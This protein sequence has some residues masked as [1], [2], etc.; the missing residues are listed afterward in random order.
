MIPGLDS[1]NHRRGEPVTWEYRNDTTCLFVRTE[2]TPN[3][4]IFNNYGAKSNEELLAS[5]GFV[6]PSGPDDVLVLALRGGDSPK[7]YYWQQSQADP[8]EELLK[9]LQEQTPLTSDGDPRIAGLLQQA[10]VIE[11][12]EQFIR[13]R[14]SLFVR[15]QME[16]D[17]SVSWMAED[18]TDGVRAQVLDHI[19]VYRQ[20]K[21]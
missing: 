3:A 17:D 13:M 9:T 19:R 15:T 10:R 5:Y 12:L 11:A 18:G 6:Q 2:I 1:F 14:R 20:G 8:P 16:V 4:Q 21:S 7:H